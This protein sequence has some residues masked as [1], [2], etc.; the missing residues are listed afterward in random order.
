MLESSGEI[1]PGRAGREH[2][3]FHS[4]GARIDAWY[5][6]PQPAPAAGP[7]PAL[8][9]CQGFT[10]TKEEGH[11]LTFLPGLVAAGYGVLAFDYRGWGKSEGERGVIDPMA[12]VED[13]RSGLSYLETRADVDPERLG[14]FGLSVGGGIAAYAA[15]VDDRVKAAASIFGVGDG[16]LWLR[17]LRREYEWLQ[18]LQDV[19]ADRRERARGGQGRLVDPTEELMVASPERRALKG[20]GGELRTP[21]ACADAI[22]Q[23]HPADVAYRI[24]PRAMIWFSVRHDPVVP[25][26]LSELVYAAAREPKRLVTLSGYD[27]Y[28]AYL[29]HRQR[30]LDESL[31]WFQQH[32]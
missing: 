10:G 21:L 6:P 18:F 7:A 29:R 27:H 4:A 23:F 5:L 20:S 24:A 15:A 31:A 9:I 3:S 22:L 30:I 12:Q 19:A 17:A 26:E 8:V 2:V 16:E 25:H 32:R 1:D 14:L 13:V 28:G 11:Y